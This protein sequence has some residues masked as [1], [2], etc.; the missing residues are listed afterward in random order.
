VSATPDFGSAG[1]HINF[2]L[3]DEKPKFEIN[4]RS[5]VAAGLK[6]SYL[7]MQNIRIIK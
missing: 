1:V 3:E 6:A 4:E 7:L 5:M 2:Y